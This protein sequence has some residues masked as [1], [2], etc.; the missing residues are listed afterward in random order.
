MPSGIR[1]HQFPEQRNRGAALG[2]G[3]ARIEQAQQF[4]DTAKGLIE[5]LEEVGQRDTAATRHRAAA[6]ALDL[7]AALVEQHP[8][9][10]VIMKSGAGGVH[11][12]LAVAFDVG[13]DLPLLRDERRV[14][15]GDAGIEAQQFRLEFLGPTQTDSISSA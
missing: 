1:G 14:P 3:V 5:P 15:F 2:L 11:E 9:M 7:L 4:A 6:Q 10:P 8:R 12:P 13:G